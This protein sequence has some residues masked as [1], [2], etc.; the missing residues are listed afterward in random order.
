MLYNILEQFRNVLES[1]DEDPQFLKYL[2]INF[3]SI[4]DRIHWYNPKHARHATIQYFNPKLQKTE[5]FY[6]ATILKVKHHISFY[7]SIF[8]EEGLWCP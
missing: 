5:H 4:L 2:I 1:S 8:F 7:I 3:S 6:L